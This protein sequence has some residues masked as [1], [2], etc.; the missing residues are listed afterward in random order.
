MISHAHFYF[1]SSDEGHQDSYRN[2]CPTLDATQVCRV[3]NVDIRHRFMPP[4][5]A[6]G[7]AFVLSVLLEEQS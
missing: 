7:N 6:E 5:G 4:I 3:D 1:N 2:N